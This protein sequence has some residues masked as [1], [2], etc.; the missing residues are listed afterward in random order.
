M[1]Q[2]GER[3]ASALMGTINIKRVKQKEKGIETEMEEAS[4]ERLKE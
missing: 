3:D 4:R 2:R 1:K